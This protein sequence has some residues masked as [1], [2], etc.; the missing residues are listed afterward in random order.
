MTYG[1]PA[2][3]GDAR[4]AGVLTAYMSNEMSGAQITLEFNLRF[5]GVANLPTD[6]EAMGDP[7]FQS[8]VD[9]LADWPGFTLPVGSE[10]D[11]IDPTTLYAGKTYP[12]TEEVTPTE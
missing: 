12:T 6:P 11:S 10:Y 2:Q 8:L 9:Y 7:N 5:D 3:S 1:M 4:Y